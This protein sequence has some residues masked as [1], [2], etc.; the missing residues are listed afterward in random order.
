MQ[1]FPSGEWHCVYCS[2]KFC[3]MF[4]GNTC[5]RD[6][7]ENVAVS[8]LITCHLCEEKCINST[9]QTFFLFWAWFGYPLMFLL[10]H[11]YYPNWVHLAKYD[12]KCFLSRSPILYSGK[13]CCKWWFP[14]TILLWEELS[15]GITFWSVAVIIAWDC[16]ICVG[17]AACI[18]S[19]TYCL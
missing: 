3:G 1:K 13:G 15:R 14:W 19:F 2:C 5:Q 4:C 11:P 9:S 8:A 10:F 7:D 18:F 6:G 16:N 12:R 17:A